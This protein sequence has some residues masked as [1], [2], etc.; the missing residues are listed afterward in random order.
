MD[1][2][3][4]K[5]VIGWNDHDVAVDELP[6]KMKAVVYKAKGKIEYSPDLIDV[7]KPGKGELLIK[8]EAA[9]LHP[10]DTYFTRGFYNG[11]YKY[12]LVPGQEGSG[13]VIAAGEGRRAQY[14]LGARVAF[15]KKVEKPGQYT[16]G[17]SYAEY[18]VT[19]AYL[20]VRLL[21]EVSWEQGACSIANPL[22]A[23]GLLDK[24]LE[25]NAWAVIQ[26]GAASTMGRL[27]IR[28][29]KEND[30]KV[31]NVVRREE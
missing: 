14:L 29:F 4:L 19:D 7:P 12:P 24:C 26:T 15:V 31:I 5:R 20:A 6:K 21:D 1:L 9:A 30:I 8:V 13:T 11:D 18:A 3:D 23:V 2:A 25:Y 17:G 27:M 28:L 22:S 16:A 10:S